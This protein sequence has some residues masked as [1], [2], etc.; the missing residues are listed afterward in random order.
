LS[1]KIKSSKDHYKDCLNIKLPHILT[2]SKHI[3]VSTMSDST[4]SFIGSSLVSGEIIALDEYSDCSENL[5]GKIVLIL[6]ADPGY[7]WI[8]TRDIAG[9][10][11][12]FGGPNSHM[13]VRCAELNIPA[14][15][16]CGENTYNKL[17]QK[18][19]TDLNCLSRTISY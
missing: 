7:D 12:C 17:L 18:K 15:I 14:A 1:Q 10:I 11:T 5:H 19:T 13:S 4:P 8:F 3:Y 6:N 2:E 16:G 9:L